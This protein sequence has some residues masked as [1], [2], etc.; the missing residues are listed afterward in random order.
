MDDNKFAF[1][2]S[3]S[4]RRAEHEGLEVLWE[5]VLEGPRAKTARPSNRFG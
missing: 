1:L 3:G 2:V 4:D 5:A